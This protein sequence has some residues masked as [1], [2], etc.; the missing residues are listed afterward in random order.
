MSASP[1]PFQLPG[2]HGSPRGAQTAPRCAPQVAPA[3]AALAVQ[4]RVTAFLGV[5]R[6]VG[7]TMIAALV[8]D[9]LAG[10]VSTLA[11]DADLA[12]ARGDEAPAGTLDGLLAGDARLALRRLRSAVHRGASGV[13]LLSLPADFPSTPST[14]RDA[15]RDL[16]VLARDRYERVIVDLGHGVGD[17]QARA[18]GAVDQVIVVGAGDEIGMTAV[19]AEVRLLRARG[20]P[21]DR[22]AVVANRVR[23]HAD[24]LRTRARG[25]AVPLVLT[26]PEDEHAAV[27]AWDG[28]VDPLDWHRP[29]TLVSGMQDL[30]DWIAG[31][32]AA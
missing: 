26:L 12:Q 19:A 17:L 22:V 8:A 25:L 11:L 30:A 23:G 15:L 24:A 2:R 18:L 29:G 1:R 4:P 20:A 28:R 32:G 14:P 3:L 27:A 6:E 13:E 10:R 16:L 5:G 7:T 21:P 9:R 31:P